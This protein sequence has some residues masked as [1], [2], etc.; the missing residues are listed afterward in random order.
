MSCEVKIKRRKERTFTTAGI[1]PT[2]P[3]V[4]NHCTTGWLSTDIYIG[5]LVIN[6]GDDKVFTR[7]QS[8]IVQIGGG[9]VANASETVKGIVEEAT[10]SEVNAGTDTGGTGAQL[11]VAPSKY[12]AGILLKVLTGFVAGSNTAIAAT[13][14]LAQ[15][16]AKIQG[17]I[18]ARAPINSPTLTGTPNA[19][20]PT[21][22]NNSTQIATTAY[23]Q[24]ELSGLVRR[25]T[26]TTNGSGAAT[27][28]AL[29]GKTPVI[30]EYA[31][32]GAG[33]FIGTSLYSF[34][35]G[36]GAFTGLSNS[37][38]YIAFYE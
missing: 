33:T 35:S 12:L 1:V 37:T 4:A 7:T 2:V 10:Q 27:V 38:Q 34:N 6:T 25:T 28:V 23:V 13:D 22:G 17:Q 5:E 15:A 30:A 3:T 19:P 29:I 24:T 9:S 18:N 36:T 21:A 20:T 31:T 16:L 32:G 14:T 8:G 26:F 11:F